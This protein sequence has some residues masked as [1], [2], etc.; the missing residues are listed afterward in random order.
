MNMDKVGILMALDTFCDKHLDPHSRE[1][2]DSTCQTYQDLL[3]YILTETTFLERHPELASIIHSYATSVT[4]SALNGY[5]KR[6]AVASIAAPLKTKLYEK[7]KEWV[8]KAA[9]LS[10]IEKEI[11]EIKTALL[12]QHEP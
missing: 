5:S 12:D 8:E 11:H 10:K 2:I 9:N 6:A 7:Q 1:K 3:L 4:R